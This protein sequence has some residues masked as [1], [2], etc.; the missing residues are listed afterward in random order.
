MMPRRRVERFL[1]IVLSVKLR[2]FVE[3]DVVVF[4]TEMIPIRVVRVKVAK[5]DSTVL[6]ETI[7]PPPPVCRNSREASGANGANACFP[8]ERPSV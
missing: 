4:L 6:W 5:L 3:H 8:I 2:P 1:R 7:V